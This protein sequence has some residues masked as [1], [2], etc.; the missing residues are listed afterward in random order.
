[1]R[2]LLFSCILKG[3][4]LLSAKELKKG[5]SHFEE[6]NIQ[7]QITIRDAGEFNIIKTNASIQNLESSSTKNEY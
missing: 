3:K 2:I 5:F 7:L 6:S 4:L 1:M